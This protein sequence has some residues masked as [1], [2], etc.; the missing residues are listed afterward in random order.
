MTGTEIYSRD[1]ISALCRR[2]VDHQITLYCRDPLP[3]TFAPTASRRVIGPRRLWT[4]LGL[5]LAMARDGPDA[6]FVPA[7][8]VPLI[9]PAA[10][11]VTIHDLGYLVHREAYR[12]ADWA[13]LLISTL[14]SARSGRRF[15]VDSRATA[16]DAQIHLGIPRDKIAVVYPGVHPAF[17]HGPHDP[18]PFGLAPG[19]L[20]FVGTLQPRKNLHRLVRAYAAAS[21]SIAMPPLVLAGAEGHRKKHLDAEIARLRLES[22]VLTPG[23]VSDRDLPALYRNARALVFVSLYEGFGIP[24]AEAMACGLPVITSDRG[25]LAEVVADAGL[26]VSP[27]DEEAIAA[28]MVRIQEDGGLRDRM[29][30][31]G[32]IR[33]GRFTWDAA[34]QV[35]LSTIEAALS[36]A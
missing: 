28:A 24:A 8:V 11:V 25:A 15:L 22:R 31:E 35:C 2:A 20:L 4:H 19:Y 7:H 34:A 23:Y 6:L 16:R 14:W 17:H 21:R 27:T 10:A 30:V 9:H 3:Q 1:L 29:R 32:L 18:P 12:P 5:S 26:L 33:A 36:D 13:Y